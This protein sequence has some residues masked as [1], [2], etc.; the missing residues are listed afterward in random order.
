NLERA[1]QREARNL[2]AADIEVRTTRAL[3]PADAAVL[4]SLDSRGISRVHLSEL[5]AMAAAGERTQLVEL[6][7]VEPGYPSYGRLRT[8]PAG[9]LEGIVIG[10]DNLV[11]EGLLLRLDVHV[12]W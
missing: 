7:A 11:E 2:M 10:P 1:I 12:G 4:A 9:A 8:E 3:T 5:V 6:K